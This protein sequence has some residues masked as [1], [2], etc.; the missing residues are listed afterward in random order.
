VAPS[1]LAFLQ[2]NR[3]HLMLFAVAVV[4]GSMLA[5]SLIKRVF[6]GRVADVTPAQAVQL[7][8]RR[9]ALVLDVRAPAER[10]GGHIPHA[11]HLPFSELKERVDELRQFKERPVVVS[12]QWGAQAT[13][14][15]A[16]LKKN[17]FNEVFV[18]RGGINA[19]RDANLPLEK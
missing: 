12:C 4:S 13:V 16:T 18:L 8:N 5:W 10:G 15:C 14:A 7:I 17:G 19:W 6:T 9:D 1:F 3:W 2:E 11:R